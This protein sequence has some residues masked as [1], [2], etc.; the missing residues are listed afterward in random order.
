MPVAWRDRLT[1]RAACSH[2]HGCHRDQRSK[3]R[4]YLEYHVA[5]E[6]KHSRRDD[7]APTPRELERMLDRALTSDVGRLRARLRGR[8]RK[9]PSAPETMRELAQEIA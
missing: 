2:G 9:R 1:R 7:G 5:M 6:S 4:M 3:C 8:E